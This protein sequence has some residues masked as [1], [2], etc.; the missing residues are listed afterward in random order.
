MLRFTVNGKCGVKRVTLKT[1]VRKSDMSPDY[2]GSYGVVNLWI[3]GG[4]RSTEERS[5]PRV[6]D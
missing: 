5:Q 4:T 2:P 1:S 3:A 6:S